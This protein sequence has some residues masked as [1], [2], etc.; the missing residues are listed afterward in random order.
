MKHLIIIIIIVLS[1]WSCGRVFAENN[2]SEKKEPEK[3]NMVCFEAKSLGDMD[4]LIYKVYDRQTGCVLYIV[5][6]RG[7]V[8]TSILPAGTFGSLK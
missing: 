6:H 3:T 5:C 1:L 2:V 4:P 8:A 7:N